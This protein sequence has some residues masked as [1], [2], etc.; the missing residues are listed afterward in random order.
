MTNKKS[1]FDHS[2]LICENSFKILVM[3]CIE[4]KLL[5]KMY[6]E[7][8]NLCLKMVSNEKK[9]EKSWIAKGQIRTYLYK[10]LKYNICLL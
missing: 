4:N 5:G 6:E 3:K 10:Y 7:V 2:S 9:R 1:T 8:K